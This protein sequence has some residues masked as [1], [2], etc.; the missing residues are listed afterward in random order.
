LLP[1][2]IVRRQKWGFGAPV[3]SWMR[4][5]LEQTVRTLFEESVLIEEHILEARGTRAYLQHPVP[6]EELYRPQRIWMLLML[7]LWARVFLHG[8]GDKPG[9]LLPQLARQ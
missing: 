5:G 4:R 2:E 7:E 6:G 8:K 1:R 3:R 9:F